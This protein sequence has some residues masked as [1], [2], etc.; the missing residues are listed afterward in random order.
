MTKKE[1]KFWLLSSIFLV[2]ALIFLFIPIYTMQNYG[3]LSLFIGLFLIFFIKDKNAPQKPMPKKLYQ[4]KI[5]WIWIFI[6][7]LVILFIYSIILNHDSSYQFIIV[8]IVAESLVFNYF[9]TK[10]DWQRKN[11]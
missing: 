2:I 3:F 4:K 9:G 5:F 1:Y 11:H 8:I 10:Y 7:L 6:P